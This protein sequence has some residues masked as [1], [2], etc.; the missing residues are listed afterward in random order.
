MEPISQDLEQQRQ[1]LD[2]ERRQFQE[3]QA[4]KEAEWQRRYQAVWERLRQSLQ[5]LDRRDLAARD[6]AS[7]LGRAQVT[8]QCW[9]AR[10]ARRQSALQAERARMMATAKH[11]VAAAWEQR[12]L[13]IRLRQIWEERRDKELSAFFQLCQE[14]E[15]AREDYLRHRNALRER[16]HELDARERELLERDFVVTAAWQQLLA[17]DP[18][19]AAAE[20]ELQ[21]RLRHLQ[22]IVRQP[23]SRL[24]QYE[25]E[26]EK[27]AE[28]LEALRL[29]L[30]ERQDELV[31]KQAACTARQTNVE[32]DQ[33][34]LADQRLRWQTELQ[35]LSDDRVRLQRQVQEL[36][37][38][39]ERLT[40]ILI[41]AQRTDKP[42]AVAA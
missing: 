7:E 22:R 14:K 26:L 9:Q 32:A 2:A 6:R 38:Q 37:Q 19:P 33:A 4:A 5:E 18:R 36:E 30:I 15:A 8:C 23:I 10:L 31:A 25:R 35:S 29:Q 17:N 34:T 41:G 28:Q 21:R 27:R 1:R 24:E 42:S 39:L 40:T 12:Q 16:L 20:K 3:A 11:Q 13:L